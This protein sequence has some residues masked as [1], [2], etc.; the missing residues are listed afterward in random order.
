MGI[1]WRAGRGVAAY[2]LV[3]LFQGI[4]ETKGSLLSML[5]KIISN[6]VFDIPVGLFARNDPFCLHFLIFALGLAVER[7]RFRKPLK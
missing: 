4:D 2:A 3:G 7:M 6:G 1:S 5:S